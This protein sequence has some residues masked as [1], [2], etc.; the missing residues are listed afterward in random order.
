M[1]DR[2]AVCRIGT[3]TERPYACPRSAGHLGLSPRP[4]QFRDLDAQVLLLLGSESPK[5]F[6]VSTDTC[7]RPFRTVAC[8]SSEGRHTSLM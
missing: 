6:R 3:S 5:M 1:L 4:G 7:L 8:T 2:I